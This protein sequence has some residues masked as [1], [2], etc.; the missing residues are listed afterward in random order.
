[1]ALDMVESARR[2]EMKKLG[3][4]AA[5]AAALAGTV[6]PAGAATP[7][8]GSI[9][10]QQRLLKFTG[11]ISTGGNYAVLDIAQGAAGGTQGVCPEPLCDSLT[12]DVKGASAGALRVAAGV[13]ENSGVNIAID[14]L[15]P[16]GTR[17]Y[18]GSS[19]LG[20][21][22]LTRVAEIPKPADGTYTVT[23]TGEGSGSTG[24]VMDFAGGAFVTMPGGSQLS[25]M[26]DIDDLVCP[27][28]V[29]HVFPAPAA[30]GDPLF[31]RQW[32]MQ[33]IGAPAAWARGFD[34]E[35][36]TIAILDTGVDRH[37]PEFAGRL[38]P[39]TDV[40]DGENAD[41]G[42]GPQDDN[43]HGT[44]V[45]G[46]AAAGA[47][48]GHGVRGV[49]PKATILP[50]K[51]CTSNAGCE[52]TRDLV[53]GV[54]YAI[55][56]GADVINLSLGGWEA[57][58]VTMAATG[59]GSTAGFDEIE[60]AKAISAEAAKAG[61]IVVAAAGNDDQPLCV[62]PGRGAGTLCVASTDVRGLPS[63]YS[64][65]PNG[66]ETSNGVRA[67]GGSAAGEQ[68]N[69]ACS[70]NIVSS[71]WGG[72]IQNCSMPGYA[73]YRGTSMATP[74]VTGL[75]A[76]LVQAGLSRSEVL[77][78]IR[79]TASNKG[80]SDPIMGYGI[81]DADAATEGLKPLK[82]GSKPKPKPKPDKP[83]PHGG[84]NGRGKS[85][86]GACRLARRAAQKA[87]RTALKARRAAHKTRSRAAK[88]RLARATAAHRKAQRR[89]ARRCG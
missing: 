2:R 36:V 29:R 34:G 61:V 39:G 31:E 4:A 66:D 86:S 16:D 73:V 47:G 75:A 32:N 77:E 59:T 78:R 28:N 42:A 67:P 44:H 64:A 50:V 63:E 89:V 17:V 85:E 13:V 26:Q 18:A 52:F 53:D 20:G 43:G 55:A 46:I 11:Q 69:D 25:G 8:T 58:A 49:A 83:K 45:A 7:E 37:H 54:R 80:A 33:Q 1:M 84:A 35:G 22:S 65:L 57:D 9:D 27:S 72:A 81:V 51:I 88:R 68:V 10:P 40:T 5:L 70:E 79:M 14:V 6:A 74:H 82:P 41:C 48:D 38:L 24:G 87:M 21:L 62:W 60:A 71:V 19:G 12:V 3:V 15:K 23:I 56:Q 76:L 30:G